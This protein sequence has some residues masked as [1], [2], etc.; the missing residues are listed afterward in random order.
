MLSA[1]IFAFSI[2]HAS[3]DESKLSNA[4]K[5]VA[6]LQSF[7]SGDAAAMKKYVN[8]DKYIQHN[9]YFP[10]GI[11][12]VAGTVDSGAFKGTLVNNYRTIS[13]GDFAVVQSLYSGAWNKKSPLVVIDVFRFEDG[14]I[15]EHWDNMMALA[16][17]PNPSGNTQLDG[18]T[19]LTD[20]DKT[21]ANRTMAKNYIDTV[22]V[23]GQ[24]DK[25][26]DFVKDN[27]YIQHH[28]D[29]ANGVS[30]LKAALG[31]FA[32][33]GIVME[34]D[35]IHAVHA[36]GSFALV[37]SEGKFGGKH[38]AYFDFLGLSGGHVN[39]HWGI[40]APIPPKSDWKNSNGKF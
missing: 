35:K 3:A 12:P 15:V 26:G 10:D 29:I 16:S 25:I 17:K 39:Q 37:M 38:Y 9:P 6:V 36:Q 22:L 23:K 14:L 4:E 18:V 5:A 32:K 19:A 21:D 20:I 8:P 33:K 11:G 27:E 40:M 24:I 7:Q 31:A 30:G 1:A 28:P 13:D 34:Y 2:G